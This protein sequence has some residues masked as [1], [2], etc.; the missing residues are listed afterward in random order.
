MNAQ[1]F[2][3]AALVVL[4]GIFLYSRILDDT[5]FYYINRRFVVLTLLAS[6]G[7]ILVGASYYL[8]SA[9]DGANEPHGDG[10]VQAHAS[11]THG[12]L[13]VLSFLIVVLPLILGWMVPA[14]PLGASALKTRETAIG[15][16][17]ELTSV[18]VPQDSSQTTAIAAGEK[19]ILDWLN[20]FSNSPDPATFNG[21]KARIVGFVYRDDRF[22]EDHFLVT[23]YLVSCCVAD[24]SAV[25]LVAQW[26]DAAS[27]PADQW[28][29]IQGEFQVGTVS[30]LHLPVLVAN[31]LERIEPPAHPYLYP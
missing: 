22:P 9:G 24:A 27:L 6:V 18:T 2:L 29:E 26:P 25:G 12:P 17:S 15:N 16:S 19:S 4:L 7:F 21:E 10:T 30:D 8:L 11:H 1:R 23:R 13:T 28:V 3:K 20:D 31:T 14:Q 5:I